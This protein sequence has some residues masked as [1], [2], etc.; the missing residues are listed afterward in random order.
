MDKIKR[1]EELKKIIAE[2]KAE[3]DVLNR[4]S[5]SGK[6]KKLPLDHFFISRF[7]GVRS[8]SDSVSWNGAWKKL[9]E[10]TKYLWLTPKYNNGDLYFERRVKRIKDMTDEEIALAVKF[11]NE[12]IPIWNK[13]TIEANKEVEV[14]VNGETRKVSVFED[15]LGE[16]FRDIIEE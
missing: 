9:Q 4:I 15:D 1:R 3:L 13:Y 12:I 6:V 7:S 10:L 2:A 8:Y 14:D 11:L 5:L 16:V